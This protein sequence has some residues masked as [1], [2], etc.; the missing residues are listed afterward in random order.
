MAKADA[1]RIDALE[2]ELGIVDP[3]PKPLAEISGY[4]VLMDSQER[5]ASDRVSVTFSV[6][7]KRNGFDLK[8]NSGP[9]T[10]T[11]TRFGLVRAMA[12]LADGGQ[13]PACDPDWPQEVHPGWTFTL[14]P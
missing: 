12:V 1:A 11:P 4:V 10:L 13:I 7:S 14:T 5:E 9:I 2:R 6:R 3:A 8:I